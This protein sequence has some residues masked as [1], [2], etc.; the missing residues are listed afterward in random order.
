MSDDKFEAWAIVE[1]FGHQKYAGKVTEATIGGCSFV[2]IDI[3]QVGNKQ[4]FSKMFGNG[5]IYAITPVTE[6]TARA[7]AGH[8][9]QEPVTEWDVR[10][11]FPQLGQRTLDEFEEPEG[12]SDD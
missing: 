9:R 3:P 10:Q 1:V 12:A 2:R 11:A 6:E 8:L 7:I 4:P 5:A